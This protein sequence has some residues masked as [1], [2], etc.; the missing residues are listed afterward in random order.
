VI[1]IKKPKTAPEKLKKQGKDKTKTH[2]LEYEQD[3]QD[4]QSGKKTF[5]FLSDIY[6]DSSSPI[7]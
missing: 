7:H 2:I 5:K 1:R 4:Y 6:G 3:P